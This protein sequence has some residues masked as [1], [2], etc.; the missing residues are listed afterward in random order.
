M[1]EFISTNETR[2]NNLRNC[3]VLIGSHLDQDLL[4][5]QFKKCI[6]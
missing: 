6:K 3:F 2:D 4:I 1:Y 5:E